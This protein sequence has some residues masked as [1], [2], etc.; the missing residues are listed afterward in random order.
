MRRINAKDRVGIDLEQVNRAKA[1]YP[2]LGARLRGR[3]LL[4]C[5]FFLNFPRM[6]DVCESLCASVSRKSKRLK[7]S[8]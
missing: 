7:P 6:A 8:C 2:L 5:Y 1:R 3:T 4:A